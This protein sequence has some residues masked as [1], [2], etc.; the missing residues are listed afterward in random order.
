M[1]LSIGSIV[2]DNQKKK[3]ILCDVIGQGGFG[4]VYKAKRENDG[5]IFAI[6][7]TLSSFYD[8]NS[9]EAFK[10][11]ICMALK[12]NSDNVI[13]YEFA[14][15]GEKYSELPPYIIMEYADNGTLQEV[16]SQHKKTN[17]FFKEDELSNIFRQLAN[18]M[19]E[20]NSLLV[21]R[22]IK[23]ENILIC[24]SVLKI[25]DFGLSKI[26]IENTRTMTFKG[27]GTPLYMSPE[28]WDYK[29]NTI[30][31]DIYSMGIIFYK[32]ATL[33]YP[34]T[35]YPKNP[36]DARNLHLYS[37]I[38]NIDNFNNKLSPR[39]VSIINRM[40]EKPLN[41]RFKNW[42]DII[43]SLEQPRSSNS[44]FDNIIKTAVIAKNSL[45]LQRQKQESEIAQ[46][47]KE[48]D[49][50]CKLV[51]SQFNNTIISV[52]KE[53]VNKVNSEYAG[54]DKARLEYNEDIN[55]Q[56]NYI[57]CRLVVTQNN[58]VEIKVEIVLKKNHVRKVPV[59][60]YLNNNIQYRK[61][62]YIPQYQG[63]N[64]MAFVEISNSNGFGYNLL[65]IDSGEIYG[66]WLIMKNRNNFILSSVKERKEPFSFSIEELPD[67]IDKVQTTYYY[68]SDFE[69]YSD[70]KFIEII[71]RLALI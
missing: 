67:E 25:S 24:G 15:D 47:K 36:E 16:I 41:R 5:K 2:M 59:H 31:M 8:E 28:A 3:Y 38:Q 26:A 4:Y 57:S 37:S 40:L 53:Y 45:D 66:D 58:Y 30:Q 51:L 6:K 7:T 46:R 39:L 55:L 18:G 32:L 14:N 44:S 27:G 69:E 48:T 62:E 71:N 20:I 17:S 9:K 35:P 42:N 50:F 68:S 54:L 13:H 21:H 10:N 12:I 49:D 63:K 64:I 29:K 22:D 52:L 23:P 19:N 11:E 33:E 70:D 43:Q 61:E 34:Y 65:L 56:Q 1:N 60:S